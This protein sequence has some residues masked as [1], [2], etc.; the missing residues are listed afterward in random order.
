LNPNSFKSLFID[1]FWTKLVAAIMAVTLWTYAYFNSLRQDSGQL[2][3]LV[4]K[5]P[6]GWEV[7]S[8]RPEQVTVTLEYPTYA[9]DQVRVALGKDIRAQYKV[10]DIPPGLLYETEVELSERNFHVPSATA[11]RVTSWRPQKISFKIAQ[12]G[13]MELKVRARPTLVGVSQGYEIQGEAY[14]NPPSVLVKGPLFALQK[15][16]YINTVD[17]PV[18]PPADGAVP[19]YTVGVQ[20][21]V[22][23]EGKSYAVTCSEKVAVTVKVRR[24]SETRSFDNVKIRVMME[25]DFPFDVKLQQ[26]TMK[27]HVKGTDAA[28]NQLKAEDIQLFVEVAGLTPQEAPYPQEVRALIAGRAGASDLEVVPDQPKVGVTVTAVGPK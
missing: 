5:A 16:R 6:D 7:V 15:A 27:V 25:S 17:I 23:V 2:I 28:L 14:C 22:E 12:E 11:A 3:P 10:N 4:I 19:Q 1:N 20:P 9:T 26:P 8:W 18:A 13:E 24:V 21:T